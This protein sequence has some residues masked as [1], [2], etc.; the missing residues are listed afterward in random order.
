MLFFRRCLGADGSGPKQWTS[1]E[2]C[3]E[4]AAR[5]FKT[6]SNVTARAH[7]VVLAVSRPRSRKR[8]LGPLREF[9]GGF[10]IT[11]R[12]FVWGRELEAAFEQMMEHE[13][14]D[15]RARAS[16]SEGE[17]QL[18]TPPSSNKEAPDRSGASRLRGPAPGP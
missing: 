1:K 14:R 15:L 17:G 8:E 6:G 13:P 4:R 5:S 18:T 12:G 7:W 2:H 16:R 10:G 11:L 3:G 9:A